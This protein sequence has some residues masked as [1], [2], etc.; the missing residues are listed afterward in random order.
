[1]G[2]ATLQ[3]RHDALEKSSSLSCVTAPATVK[4]TAVRLLDPSD[5]H[6][7]GLAE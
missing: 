1:M 5:Q 4:S 3:V 7:G 2:A 6:V